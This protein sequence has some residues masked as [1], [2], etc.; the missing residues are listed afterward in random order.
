MGGSKEG[1]GSFIKTFKHLF[2]N[3]L[4]HLFFNVIPLQIY[5]FIPTVLKFTILLFVE[6]WVLVLQI[7][8]YSINSAIIHGEMLTVGVYFYLFLEID[9]SLREPNQV[10]KAD[11]QLD[12]SR[13][14]VW[15]QELLRIYQLPDKNV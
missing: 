4:L 7:H 15:P 9:S 13:N 8:L 1:T 6:S 3:K 5:I 14:H 2:H 12:G 10:K 11:V